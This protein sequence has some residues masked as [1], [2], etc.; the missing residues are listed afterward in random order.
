MRKDLHEENRRSWNAATTAHNSHKGDQA[1]F[2][3]HGGNKLYSEEKE[4]LGDISGLSVVHL[5]CN[6]GQD[7]LSIANM[8]AVVTGVDMSDTAI[9]YARTLSVDSGVPATFSRMDV[10]EWFDAAA[11]LHQQFDIVFCSY[12]VVWWLSD[13]Q[14]WARGIATVLKPGG[15]FITVDYH[16]VMMLF[17]EQGMRVFSYFCQEKVAPMEEGVPDYVAARGK[18]LS[19]TEYVEGI[20]AFR[21]PYKAYRFAWGI[22]EIV[23]ALLSA[24]LQVRHLQEY[25][26]VNGY[27][28]FLQMENRGH[29]WFLPADQPNLPLMYAI[30]AQKPR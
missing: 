21:N 12:G 24:G 30:I 9:A 20:S 2:F 5:L 23:T 17:N 28:P 4:L 8:G 13:V 14:A 26:H 16:P 29:Q 3:R 7:T 10:F 11:Q 18:G 25:P 6:A 27:N 1:S 19:D 15:R 22:G